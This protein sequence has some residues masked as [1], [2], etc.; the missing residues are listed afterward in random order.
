MSPRVVWAGNSYF[1]SPL[2]VGCNYYA[3]N[4][5]TEGWKVLFSAPP[6]TPWHSFAGGGDRVGMAGR[7]RQIAERLWQIIPFTLLPPAKSR[8]Y[9]AAVADLAARHWHRF[10]VPALA[11]Q[12]EGLGFAEADAL[13]VDIFS[14]WPLLQQI[15]H[16]QLIVRVTD[17]LA[18]FGVNRAAL[19]LERELIERADRVFYTARALRPGLEKLNGRLCY[20][21]N[22]V[23][24]GRYRVR[25][26]LPDEYRE[27]DGTIAVYVGAIDAW[28][29]FEAMDRAIDCLPQVQFF[30]IGPDGLARRRLRSRPNLHLLGRRS[31]GQVAALL[32][33]AHVGL[34]PFDVSRHARLVECISPLK[35]FEYL[36]AGLP[37]VSARWPEVEGISE[38]VSFYGDA[39][40]FVEALASAPR[41][42]SSEPQR[43]RFIAQHSWQA[44]TRDFMAA[45]A[46]A[47][48]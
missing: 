3:S 36:A 17:R 27:V 4:L 38:R 11:P 37:V 22:G 7:P 10:C 41:E 31:P 39:A 24:A 42:R 43:Q 28:F 23:D 40:E 13:V 25:H 29:D 46:L 30:V 2:Q 15:G 6:V 14:A 48:G 12:I 44:R 35:L 16:K 33:H 18:G 9:P 32:Q 5:A 8:R 20:L 1:G 26:A 47:H 45:A 34:L 21:P 19:A